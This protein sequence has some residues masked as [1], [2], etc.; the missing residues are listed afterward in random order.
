MSIAGEPANALRL[1]H[2]I[3][4][5]TIQIFT[6]SPNRWQAPPLTDE[7]AAAFRQ[8]Q[9]E[10]GIHPVV[11]HSAYLI[12]LATPDEALWRRS[13]GAAVEELARCAGLGV[14]DYVLHPGAHTG[15]G[16]LPGLRRI[17][18][19]LVAL[20]EAT[21]EGGVRILLE[22]TSGAGTHLGYRLEHL[23]W[24]IEHAGA[25]ERLG[26]CLDTAHLYGAGYT[27][28]DRRSYRSFWAEF[29][30]LI[31][32]ERLGAIHLNDSAKERGSR[33]DRH[34]QIGEGLMGVAPFA[35]LVN[36]ARLAHAPMILET[37][38]GPDLREDVRNLA[39]LRSLIRQDG[40]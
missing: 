27:L 36:D 11:A 2:S 29:E 28:H 37:P 38:K 34:A 7:Q 33:G 20:L 19:G 23:A 14:G 40:A 3:G 30:A 24:L 6:R 39:L 13:I 26:V 12:N 17:A 25:G 21:A 10:T 18:E 8:A 35:M 9:E 22:T 31:G 15:A 5:E 4:C 32:I 1:G 16:E